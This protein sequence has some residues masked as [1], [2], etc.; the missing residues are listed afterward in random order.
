MVT[1]PATRP[2]VRPSPVFLLVLAVAA[3]GGVVAWQAAPRSTAA[4]VGVF[5]MVVA[6]WVVT[7]CVHEFAHAVT[8]WRHGDGVAAR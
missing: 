7:V 1:F 5:T 4:S 6:G 2:A 8:A 3:A